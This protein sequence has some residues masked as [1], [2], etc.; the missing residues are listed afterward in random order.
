MN[1]EPN[2]KQIENELKNKYQ[3]LKENEIILRENDFDEGKLTKSGY[4]SLKQ[5]SD[6]ISIHDPIEIR[7]PKKYLLA[8]KEQLELMATKELI[9]IKKDMKDAR[10]F[11]AM[12]FTIGL[13]LLTIPSLLSLIDVNI[14][15]INDLVTIISWVF[16]WASVEKGFFDMP[17]LKNRRIN[18]LHLLTSKIYPYKREEQQ[19][20]SA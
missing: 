4:I 9:R 5:Q 8:F 3:H 19:N 17:Q 7:M 10:W 15:I 20:E 12:F 2:F 11:S 13:L 18:I 1:D 14:R 16:V 6:Y